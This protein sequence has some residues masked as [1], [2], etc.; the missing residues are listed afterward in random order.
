MIENLISQKAELICVVPADSKSIVAAI[1]K[2]NAARIPIIVVDN[3]VD[4]DAAAKAGAKIAGYIGSDNFSGG[5]LA[6]GFRGSETRRSR[7]GCDS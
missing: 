4:P 5:T 3:K 1:L 2:A 7:Q 6:G